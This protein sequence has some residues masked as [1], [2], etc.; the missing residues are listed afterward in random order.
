MADIKKIKISG[1]TY[2]LKDDS[3]VKKTGDTMTGSLV[4]PIIQ[5]GTT[6][7][8]YFQSQKF[9]GEGDASTYYHAVDFGYTNHNQVDFY[10]YGGVYNFWQNKTPTATSDASNKIA[11]LQ[12]GKLVERNNTLTYPGKSGTLATLDDIPESSFYY[13][14]L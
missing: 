10:E 9:R 5:T 4:A 11:S 13:V 7:T 12:L 14:E 6:S 8:N 1:V 2:N 3:A